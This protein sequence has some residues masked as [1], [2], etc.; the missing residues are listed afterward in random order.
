MADRIHLPPEWFLDM[1]LPSIRARKQLA[2]F[3][4]S[5]PRSRF[6]GVLVF[7][8]RLPISVRYVKMHPPLQLEGIF[9]TLQKRQSTPWQ[10]VPHFS[11]MCRAC[12]RSKITEC[13]KCQKYFPL[14]QPTKR[15]E[16]HKV[17]TR[18]ASAVALLL[19]LSQRSREKFPS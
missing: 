6:R 2:V 18:E 14:S 9:C 8:V 5:L 7:P 16:E 4:V 1:Q 13:R 17:G 12:T 19:S 15:W 10:N 3:S 11:A